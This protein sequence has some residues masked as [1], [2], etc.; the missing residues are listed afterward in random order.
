[1]L[2]LK[3]ALVATGEYEVRC[4][5]GDEKL[6]EELHRK[7]SNNLNWA[8]IILPI[9]T[10][11]W[12]ESH[13]CRDEL[14]R[15]HERRKRIV[16]FRH[17]DIT[18]DGPPRV[19][20]FM[21]E[22]LHVTW[23]DRDLPRAILELQ[24]KMRSIHLE[25]WKYDSFRNLRSIG[26]YIH[27]LDQLPRWKAL[28][29]RRLLDREKSQLKQIITTD[30]CSFDVS[31][32][33]SYLAFADSM[34]RS[35]ES[36]IAVCI[37]SISTFWTNPDFRAPASSYLTHQEYARNIKRLFV[38]SSPDEA[39]QYK[40]VLQAHHSSYGR[41]AGSGVF[42]CT[43]SAY[44]KLI[45]RWNISSSQN[46]LK[47][48]FGLLKFSDSEKD[49]E[50]VLDTKE[51]RYREFG[52]EEPTEARNKLISEH[53]D[54]FLNIPEG[55][56]DSKTGIAQWATFLWEDTSAFSKLLEDLFGKRCGEVAHSVFLKVEMDSDEVA[57]L[58]YSLANRFYERRKEL[59]I[60]NV[61]VH[62][63]IA[64][65]AQDGRFGGRISSD[66][67]FDYCIHFTFSDRDA[68]LHYYEH[69]LHSVERE[70]LYCLINPCI[71]KE[72]DILHGIPLN[73]EK[74]RASQFEKIEKIMIRGGFIQR[75][76]T[77]DDEPISNIVSRKG[78]PFL[79]CDH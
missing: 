7:I 40:N 73:Q 27:G 36:I 13:E 54:G 78:T 56:V 47:Q 15:A 77:L 53:F 21:R 44:E 57:S 49:M 34:F 58:I 14:V 39:N 50:A 28:L 35:A 32:E 68:L 17:H 62:R 16:L 67:V 63:D 22:M 19:P 79:D 46:H 74:K 48:D 76:D 9:V 24:D 5:V 66:P 45:S 11:H 60:L 31:H 38:F 3:S 71:R 18:N 42:L 26:D 4:D 2:A 64:T 25:T 65:R 41:R 59:K 23:D 20:H 8:D 37:A 72:F 10:R 29:V 69:E 75:K 55:Q 61:T 1:M 30:A 52:S 33:N 6:V 51:F 70:H 43:I 12:L